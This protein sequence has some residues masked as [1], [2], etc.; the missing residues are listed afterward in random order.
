MLFLNQLKLLNNWGG[1]GVE[2]IH[3]FV[4][5]P[6]NFFLKSTLKTTD[7]FKL[8]RQN[9]NMWTFLPPNDST[10]HAPVT[11]RIITRLFNS[12]IMI[13]FL[14]C[15]SLIAMWDTILWLLY[16]IWDTVVQPIYGM[17]Y[18][19]WNWKYKIVKIIF[20]NNQQ[21]G[22]YFVWPEK[23]KVKRA[24]R[25]NHWALYNISEKPGMFDSHVRLTGVWG[26][27]GSKYY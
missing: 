13:I 5:Y 16:L 14:A 4:F 22:E 9:K 18:V 11:K 3:I 10:S 23:S 15:S 8:V 21:A 20:N 6:T 1:G 2:Y 19:H 7:F 12:Y 25:E 17:K 27:T 26:I 24:W